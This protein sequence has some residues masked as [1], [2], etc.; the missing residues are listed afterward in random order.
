MPLPGQENPGYGVPALTGCTSNIATISRLTFPLV[1]R[2]W[3]G[4]A[5]FPNTF[6]H[7]VSPIHI[8]FQVVYWSRGASGD[9]FHHLHWTVPPTRIRCAPAPKPERFSSV[10]WSAGA[11]RSGD[12]AFSPSLVR[13]RKHQT[14]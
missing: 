14:V 11:E 3:P 2:Y 10:L 5:H 8:G 13:G 9:P 1:R 4:K 7:L 6:S 12:P